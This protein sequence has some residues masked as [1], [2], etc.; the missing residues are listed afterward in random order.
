[1]KPPQTEKT[2]FATFLAKMQERFMQSACSL[3]MRHSARRWLSSFSVRQKR[4]SVVLA[5]QAWAIPV[6][7][8]R[9]TIAITICCMAGRE[10]YHCKQWI[11]DSEEQDC[12]TTTEA[13]LT[14][15]LSNDLRDAWERL[16]ETA[17]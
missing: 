3:V 9:L 2:S 16:R 11:E 15:E 1:M 4:L 8:F 13:V 17:V 14:Q 12:W 5:V 6:P 7:Q 10:C